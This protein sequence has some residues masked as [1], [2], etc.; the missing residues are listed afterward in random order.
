[1]TSVYKIITK[2]L[3]L[4]ISDMLDDTI[5]LTQ[6]V[7]VGGRQILHASLVTNEVVD[8]ICWSKKKD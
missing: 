2:V 5:S 6:S 4:R 8:F 3:L 1:M 7:F